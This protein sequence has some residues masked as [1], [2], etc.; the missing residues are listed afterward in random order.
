MGASVRGRRRRGAGRPGGR[1]HRGAGPRHSE[2][3]ARVGCRRRLGRRSCGPPALALRRSRIAVQATVAAFAPVAAVAIGI[4][5]ATSNMFLMGEDERVLWVVLVGAG[6]SGMAASLVLGRRV[7]HASQS[8]TELARRLGDIGP[9][10]VVRDIASRPAGPGELA[11]LATQLEDASARLAEAQ[12]H[13]AANE[14]SRRELV[15]W[16]SHDLRTPLAGIR[17]MVEALE[18]GVVEDPATVARYYATMRLEADRLAGLVDDLF[19]LS[20]IQSGTLSLAISAVPLDD[21][22]ADAIEGAGIAAHA[23]GVELRCE[24]EH[25]IPMVELATP[26]MIRVVRNLLDNAIHHTPRSGSVTLS[27][28]VDEAGS[29][30]ELSV[31]DGCGGI[32]P[33]DLRRV[34]ETGY[35]GDT[36]RTPGDGRGGLGLAIAHGLVR[37]HSGRISVTNSGPGCRFTVQLPLHPSREHPPPEL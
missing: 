34:F 23:K 24:L 13:A 12:A 37:A 18:D 16:V 10:A 36:A 22:V 17:A 3:A 14:A 5:W 2:V 25:P 30:V 11:S 32:P 28:G 9:A 31:C 33:Q 6:A 27:A 26:E 4:M 20:R 15:A 35:R 19:E 8:V 29:H 21:I 1:S 7:A